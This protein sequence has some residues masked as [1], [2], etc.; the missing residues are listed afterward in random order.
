MI[1]GCISVLKFLPEKNPEKIFKN[2]LTS[3]IYGDIITTS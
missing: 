3:K 2:Y 1:N